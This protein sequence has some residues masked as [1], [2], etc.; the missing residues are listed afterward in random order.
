M[1]K[2]E[3]VSLH[4]AFN[5]TRCTTSRSGMQ[6]FNIAYITENQ[7][8]ESGHLKGA[9]KSTDLEKIPL[10]VVRDSQELRLRIMNQPGQ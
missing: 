3:N 6:T 5:T 2:Q 7:Q 10:S 1:S 8:G 4:I 9:H